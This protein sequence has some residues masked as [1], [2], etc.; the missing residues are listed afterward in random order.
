MTAARPVFTDC[1]CSKIFA[2]STTSI[3]LPVTST[4][5]AAHHAQ[6][7]IEDNGDD[8]ADR[9]RDE[10]R[11]GAVRHHAIVHVHR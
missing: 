5:R 10:R 2:A 6:H 11:N 1:T 3:F 8:H 4:M 7:E 9:E